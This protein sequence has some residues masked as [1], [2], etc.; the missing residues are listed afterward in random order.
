MQ[1]TTEEWKNSVNYR[2][3]DSAWTHHASLD[4]ELSPLQGSCKVLA[5]SLALLFVEHLGVKVANLQKKDKNR[6]WIQQKEVYSDMMSNRL[7]SWKSNKTSCKAV[8]KQW[9]T[10]Y[11]SNIIFIWTV[12]TGHIRVDLEFWFH[13]TSLDLRGTEA[14][15]IVVWSST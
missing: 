7:S 10:S 4:E 13:T 6:T 11:L 1:S 9:K 3:A 8:R 2:R 15:G 14:V 12:V 5:E